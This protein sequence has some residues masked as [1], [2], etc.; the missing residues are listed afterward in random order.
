[1]THKIVS[2][3]PFVVQYERYG[4]YKCEQYERPLHEFEIRNLYDT[5]MF[6]KP[7]MRVEMFGDQ[8]L[9]TEA[10]HCLVYLPNIKL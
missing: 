2:M 5:I 7:M 10:G 3:K 4:V 1:M 8:L 6:D 9:L